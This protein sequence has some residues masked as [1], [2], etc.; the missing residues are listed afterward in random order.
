MTA[1]MLWNVGWIY[2]LA[3]VAHLGLGVLATMGFV[4]ER[5]GFKTK[6]LSV[7]YYFALVNA[8]ANSFAVCRK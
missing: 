4:A 1:A 8:A 5:R 6:I 3:V 7:P 2:R